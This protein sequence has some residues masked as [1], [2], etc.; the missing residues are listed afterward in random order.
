MKTVNFIASVLILA[1]LVGCK[2]NDKVVTPVTTKPVLAFEKFPK[3]LFRQLSVGRN[4]LVWG[5]GTNNHVYRL[6]DASTD[7]DEPTSTAL[8]TQ[9]AV[10]SD[11]TAWGLNSEN[12][13]FKWNGTAWLFVNQG[14][15]KQISVGKD[16]L[17]W[18]IG[19]NGHV[20]RLNSAGTDWDEPVS[21]AL[22]MQ[23]SVSADGTVWGVN[24]S[25][26]IFQLISK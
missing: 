5:I 22:L 25:N 16:G 20:Y 21:T 4:K 12:K 1:L 13:I 24:N 3:G 10:A 19:T 23:V 11:G 17:V 14:L 6:N 7:W 15:L 8:L 2:K 9:V 18:G 26:E